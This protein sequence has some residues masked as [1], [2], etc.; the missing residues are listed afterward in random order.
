MLVSEHR[1][2]LPSPCYSIGENGGID[3]VEEVV[4]EGEDS[5]LEDL[6][7]MVEFG[8]D[9]I[10]LEGVLLGLEIGEGEGGGVEDGDGFFGVG[11]MEFAFVEGPAAGEDF[12]GI[13]GGH[14]K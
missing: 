11:L 5:L 12:E 10:E 2:R 13:K 6:L 8:E 1:M 9:S 4:G 7:I 3:A 14:V